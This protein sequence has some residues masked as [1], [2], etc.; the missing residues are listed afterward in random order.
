MCSRQQVLWANSLLYPEMKPRE[1]AAEGEADE[2]EKC[3][4]HSE[5]LSPKQQ[6]V[7]LCIQIHPPSRWYHTSSV[8]QLTA[9]SLWR[10]ISGLLLPRLKN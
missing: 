10:Y 7:V 9:P 3:Q 6:R 8:S 1:E 5:S 4:A 2:E